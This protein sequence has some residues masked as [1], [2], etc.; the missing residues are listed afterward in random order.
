MTK[1][2]GNVSKVLPDTLNAEQ[3]RQL[4]ELG[5]ANK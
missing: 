3:H 1:L 4:T 2:H 5:S